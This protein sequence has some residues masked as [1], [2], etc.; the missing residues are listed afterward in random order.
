M[1]QPQLHPPAV[2]DALR[3]AL[4]DFAASTQR[5]LQAARGLQILVT[6]GPVWEACAVEQPPRKRAAAP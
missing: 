5:L 4:A 2:D 3:Q 6:T 1:P